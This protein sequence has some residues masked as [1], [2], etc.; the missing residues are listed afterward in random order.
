VR[1]TAYERTKRQITPSLPAARRWLEAGD[2]PLSS[3]LEA[4]FLSSVNTGKVSDLLMSAPYACA[5]KTRTLATP[6]SMEDFVARPVI[7]GLATFDLR[8]GEML[9]DA[10]LSQSLIQS[11][12]INLWQFECH[13]AAGERVFELTAGLAER[14]LHTQLRGLQ[15]DDLRLPYPSIYLVIPPELGLKIINEQTGDHSLEGIYIT[16]Y[17]LRGV[18]RWGL[19][20][21]GPSNSSNADDDAIFHFIVDLPPDQSLEDALDNNERLQIVDCLPSTE[22]FYREN[23]RKLFTLVLNTVVYCT[24][25]DADKRAVQNPRYTKLCEQVQRH[26]KGSTKRT[27][28]QGELHE[29]QQQRRVLLGSSSK[30]LGVGSGEGSAVTVRTLVSGHW[31]RQVF[32]EGRA[33]RKWIFI[34]PF[35]RG[36]DDAPESNPR[37]VLEAVDGA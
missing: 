11:S 27:R 29:T 10:R 30:P 13:R 18:R 36:P 21:W 33:F 4:L 20:L 14:L 35:W 24:W 5:E 9:Y 32:G 19:L 17:E 7:Q 23:W 28:I 15:T 2:E 25:P 31:K 12:I 1:E 26:P 6:Y 16:E 8:M 37:R 3:R 34:S 22:R